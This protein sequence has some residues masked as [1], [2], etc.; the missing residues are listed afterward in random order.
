MSD[1]YKPFLNYDHP[2]CGAHLEEYIK[3]LPQYCKLRTKIH[4][5]R[6]RRGAEEGAFQEGR[7]ASVTVL[8]A[9]LR[10]LGNSTVMSMRAIMNIIKDTAP[11]FPT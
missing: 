1:V 9:G 3:P 11:T 8:E 6:Q 10:D 7:A 4:D 2:S 5:F